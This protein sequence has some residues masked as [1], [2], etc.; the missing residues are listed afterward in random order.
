MVQTR[1]LTMVITAE[2][3]FFKDS[4][5]FKYFEENILDGNARR[6]SKEAFEKE[7]GFKEITIE[8]K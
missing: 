1:T 4:K 7:K 3:E 6:E 8:I 5:R 2:E